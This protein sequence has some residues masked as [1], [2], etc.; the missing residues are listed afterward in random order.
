ML[1]QHHPLISRHFRLR[2]SHVTFPCDLLQR[3]C[4]NG[5][6]LSP[7]SHVPVSAYAV[8]IAGCV[9]LIAAC[10]IFVF[11]P[12]LSLLDEG[13]DRVSW[14]TKEIPEI[15]PGTPSVAGFEVLT[16]RLRV[17]SSQIQWRVVC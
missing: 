4:I 13:T 3:R 10:S 7:R 15:A 5:A 17:L 12:A 1:R 14:Q 16:R 9:P 6:V 2:I 11:A 8:T